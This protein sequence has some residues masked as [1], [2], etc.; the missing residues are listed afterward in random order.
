VP[1]QQA[2][3]QSLFHDASV[4]V[5]RAAASQPRS[6]PA[7]VPLLLSA[8]AD[9]DENVRLFAA[10]GLSHYG[11]ASALA[12]LKQLAESDPS[13]EVRAIAKQTIQLISFH[14]ALTEPEQD[15]REKDL[16]ERMKPAHCKL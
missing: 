7:F 6:H 1:D 15:A 5:R 9:Q 4:R 11:R 8:L 2:L 16:L 3:L 13:E 10:Q 12:P 14:T